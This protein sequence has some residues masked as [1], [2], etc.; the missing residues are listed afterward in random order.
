MNGLKKRCVLNNRRNEK[1]KALHNIHIDFNNTNSNK[2]IHMSYKVI[3]QKSDTYPNMHYLFRQ[4]E[5]V[6]IEVVVLKN[7][8]VANRKLRAYE[9]EY[10][11]INLLKTNETIKHRSARRNKTT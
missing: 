2:F 5:G 1:A 11:I 7:R 8:I 9:K 4:K 10:L 6:E 3:I